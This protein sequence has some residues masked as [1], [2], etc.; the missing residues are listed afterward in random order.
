MEPQQH[1]EP[2]LVLR[3]LSNCSLISGSYDLSGGGWAASG[4]GGG[5]GGELE[6]G[7]DKLCWP[8]AL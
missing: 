7:A 1:E 3:C 8:S 4:G 5:G 2:F 6:R